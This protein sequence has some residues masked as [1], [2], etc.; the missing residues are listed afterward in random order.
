MFK[1]LLNWLFGRKPAMPAPAP[2]GFETLNRQAPL[3]KAQAASTEPQGAPHEIGATYICREAILNRQQKIAGYQFLLQAA[4][5]HHI[6]NSSRRVHHLYAEVLVNSLVHANIGSLLGPR[7]AF[8]DVP[9]SFLDHE[10]ISRL[11]PAN[12]VLVPVRLSD[13]GAPSPEALAATIRRLRSQGYNIGLPDPRSEPEYAHLLALANVV[14]IRASRLSADQA[15][16]LT[17]EIA[18]KAPQAV[19]LARDLPGLEDF[20]FCYKMGCGLFQGPFITSRE[21]WRDHQLGPNFTRLAVLAGKLRSQADTGDVVAMLKQ[22]AALTVRLLRYINSAANGLPEHV[23]SIERALILLGRDRL[24]R[25]VMLLMC[26]SDAQE[27]RA[28]AV[29]ETALVRARMMELTGTN[30]QAAERETLFLTGLLSLIDVILKVPMARAMNTLGVTSDIEAAI[31]RGEGALGARLK[32]AQAS[33]GS[34]PDALRTAAEA[35][36]IAPEDAARCQMEALAW[37]LDMQRA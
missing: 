16:A 26:S 9:D 14:F 1:K 35:C 6:R 22:D 28:S 10:C 17:A 12:M 8:I 21:D 13:A 25:W 23:S 3:R 5:L 27:G 36:G 29:L 11:P 32:L 20:S 18:D 34:D 33:E 15:L 24:Y 2:S 31:L 4:A 7:A 30:Q 19:L 37:A